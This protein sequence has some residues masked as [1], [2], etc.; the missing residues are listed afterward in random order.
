M[1]LRYTPDALA[2]L[3]DVLTYIAA[4]SE[5]SARVV[6][7]RIKAAID[8]LQDF[9]RAGR[10]T[11]LPDLRRIVVTPYPYLIFYNMTADEVIIVGI[12]HAARDPLS[13][14]DQE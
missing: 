11:G 1:K 6:Q 4:R 10:P 2:E 8:F 13:M 3:D 12:R 14:P 5:G 7:R 9:P